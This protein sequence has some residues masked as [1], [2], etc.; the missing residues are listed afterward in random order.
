MSPATCSGWSPFMITTSPSKPSR[1]L[2]AASTAWAVPSGASCTATPEDPSRALTRAAMASARGGI[3]TTIRWQPRPSAASMARSISERPP[4]ACST[5]GVGDF[6]RVPW[7]A[8]RMTAARAGL[9]TGLVK[10]GAPPWPQ[11]RASLSKPCRAGREVACCDGP[12]R[13]DQ[14]HNRCNA[15]PRSPPLASSAPAR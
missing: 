7:P 1:A 12:I 13:R 9:E 8:A 3:T 15:L 11:S 4:T 14:D 5:F 2:P 10:L 6:M